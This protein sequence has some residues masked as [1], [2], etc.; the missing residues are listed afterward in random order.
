MN[1]M[2]TNLSE[3]LRIQYLTEVEN[4]SFSLLINK[5]YTKK[6]NL[7]HYLKKAKSIPYIDVRQL[8]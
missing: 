6:I 2:V 1:K 7:I 4:K 8:V 3:K 5:A